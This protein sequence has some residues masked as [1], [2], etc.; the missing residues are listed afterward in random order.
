MELFTEVSYQYSDGE[1]HMAVKW[2]GLAGKTG[3]FLAAG[4]LIPAY[5]LRDHELLLVDSGLKEDPEFLSYLSEHDLRVYAVLQ[6]HL[7]IDHIANNNIFY[8]K[9][10]TRIFA[11][12]GEIAR[13]NT[14]TRLLHTWHIYTPIAQ[15]GYTADFNYPLEPITDAV[16][17]ITL[18]GA[19]FQ[20]VPLPGH[21]AGHLGFVTPD[22]VFC[23]GDAI[24]SPYKVDHSKL[25]YFEDIKASIESMEKIGRSRY[26][27]YALAHMEVV[28]G[29][30][31]PGLIRKNIALQTKVN[32]EILEIVNDPVPVEELIRS[33][34]YALGIQIHDRELH[35]YVWLATRHRIRY[36]EDLGLIRC[37]RRDGR[38]LFGITEKGRRL[39]M[40]PQ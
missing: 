31:M 3:Y 24:L 9:Y 15:D 29:R 32:R 37:V 7:H 1:S 36:M 5:H 13:I 26:P 38:S 34:L 22:G 17:E 11:Q 4:V 30:D 39:V 20:V 18:R 28:E 8:K 27:Y 6:T 2:I 35:D 16:Q 33:T 21:S 25:P 10:R 40:T 12:E 23:L 19:S 14:G